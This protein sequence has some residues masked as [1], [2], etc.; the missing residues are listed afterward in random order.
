MVHTWDGYTKHAWGA[1]ELKPRSGRSQN[2]WGGKW[3]HGKLGEHSLSS[4]LTSCTTLHLLTGMGMTML[5]ALDVLWIMG[6]KDEFKAARDWVASNLSFNKPRS[7]SFF[8]T[9]IRALGGL[10]AAYDLS[11]DKMFLDKAKVLWQ[12]RWC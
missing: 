8:E 11:G 5:D 1:D 2:N 4:L 12:W 7:V 3:C 10:L 6:M 9:T